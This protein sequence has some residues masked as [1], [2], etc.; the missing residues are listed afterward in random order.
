MDRIWIGIENDKAADLNI[1]IYDFY[2]D[3][4]RGGDTRIRHCG[5][6]EVKQGKK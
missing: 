4:R 2:G 1:T 6:V 3:E 5:E